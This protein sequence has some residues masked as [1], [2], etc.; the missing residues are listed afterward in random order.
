MLLCYIPCSGPSRIIFRLFNHYSLCVK[1][2]ERYRPQVADQALT[3]F[4]VV[5][6]LVV[7]SL[8][9]FGNIR[10]CFF[11]STAPIQY[12]LSLQYL[13]YLLDDDKARGGKP[14]MYQQCIA[15]ADVSAD[16]PKPDV[17]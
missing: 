15:R 5:P 9:P 16:L 17:V 7:F 13:L 3:L 10:A 12:D 4:R 1:A 8:S 14:D 6:L 2:W 11:C